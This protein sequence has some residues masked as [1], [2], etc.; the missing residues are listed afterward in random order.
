M[1]GRRGNR[2]MEGKTGELSG[3][4]PGGAIPHS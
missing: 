1:I 2:E 4:R 3:E